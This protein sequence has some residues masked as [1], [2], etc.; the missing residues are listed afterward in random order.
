VT[1]SL[2][3]YCSYA[4][5]CLLLC[6]LCFIAAVNYDTSISIYDTKITCQFLVGLGGTVLRQCRSH[7]AGNC[8]QCTL[9]NKSALQTHDSALYTAKPACEKNISRFVPILETYRLLN[10]AKSQIERLAKTFCCLRFCRVT[11][12][13]AQLMP[14]R[15]IHPSVRPSVTFMYCI[16]MSKHILEVKFRRGGVECTWR[17]KQEA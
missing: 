5:H 15:G 17:L 1:F 3:S 9:S 10:A 12:C 7:F 14:W 6:L 13:I 2:F 11:P 16:K 8:L 4:L